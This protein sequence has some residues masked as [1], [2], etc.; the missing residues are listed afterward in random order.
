MNDAL[1]PI[2]LVV[3]A[4]PGAALLWTARLVYGRRGTSS[5]DVL[6][7]VLSTASWLMLLLAF[8]GVVGGMTGPFALL[9]LPIVWIVFIM[10][11]GQYR[12]SE[13]RALLDVL[14]IAAERGLPL[15]AAARAFADE[16]ADELGLRAGRLADSLA[17]GT[18]LP[19]AL[20]SSGH[21]FLPIDAKLAVRV[22][23]ETG[24][25]GPAIRRIT[26]MNASVESMLRTTSVKFLYLF[27][28]FFTAVGILSFVMLR[29][30]PTFAK[31]FE[32]F[33]LKLPPPTL[34]LVAISD[35]ALIYSPILI[36]W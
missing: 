30:I 23:W 7:R 21:R 22:G 26:G 15:D 25:L 20:E 16:R 12:R 36:P 28:L 24:Q 19:E 14:A 5:D 4:L 27:V 8:F 3:L 1:G 35:K 2:N 32:E 6:K 9:A 33:E 29:I 34:L 17:A 11:L 13:N 10:I 31:M 18:P